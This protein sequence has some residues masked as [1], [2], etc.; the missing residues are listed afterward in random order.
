[1]TSATTTVLES[2]ELKDA[3]NTLIN[4]RDAGQFITLLGR[5][6]VLYSGRGG[7]DLEA[8]DRHVML[9]PDG[10]VIVHS[11][12]LFKPRNY[13]PPGATY[14]ARM[15]EEED[16]LTVHVHRSKGSTEEVIDVMFSDIYVMTTTRMQDD[17]DLT[18][19]GTEQ[20]MQEYL[21]RNPES[22]ED[23][24]GVRIRVL[25]TEHT[26]AVGHIDILAQVVDDETPVVIELKRRRVG[27]KAVDQLRRYIDE[28]ES[29]DSQVIGVLVAPSVTDSAREMLLEHGFH[30]V[31]FKP[32]QLV[33]SPISNMTLDSFSEDA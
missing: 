6:R 11:H 13:Q 2:P 29:I 4:A 21:S 17:A 8:G 5:C 15:D 19:V 16:V 1:M 10:T 24:L 28:Y 25:D 9:K 31:E 26:V 18:V 27:P 32:E 23:E 30:F 33:A 12:D 14:T 7:S 22:I 20:D 3:G